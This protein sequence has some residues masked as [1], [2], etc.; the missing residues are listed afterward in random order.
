MLGV[1]H[2]MQALPVRWFEDHQNDSDIF[3]WDRRGEVVKWP[4]HDKPYAPRKLNA[5]RYAGGGGYAGRFNFWHPAVRQIYRDMVTEWSQYMAKHHPG[6]MRY[7]AVGQE[8]SALYASGVNRTTVAAFRK[9]LEDKYGNISNLNETWTTQYSGFDQIDPKQADASRPNGLMY[10]L[11]LFRQDSYFDWMRLVRDCAKSQVPDMAFLND[12]HFFAGDYGHERALDLPRMF[13]TYDVVGFH[14]YNADWVWPM[15]RMLD[16]MRKAYGDKPLGNFEWAAGLLCR[17]IFDERRYKACGLRD[18]FEMMGWGRVVVAVWY[19]GSEGFSEGA[20]YWHGG[21]A[22]SV[23]RYSTAYIPVARQRAR[24][25]ERIAMSHRTIDPKLVVME[26]TASQWNGVDARDTMG[27]VA[28]ALEADDWNYGFIHE[29][30]LLEG[31]QSMDKVHTLILP[32]GVALHP[33]TETKLLAWVRQGGHLVAL[34]PPGMFDPYGKPQGKLIEAVAGQVDV[35]YN[36][37]FTH[38]ELKGPSTQARGELNGQIEVLEFAYGRGRLILF[39]QC[40]P[41]PDVELIRLLNTTTPRDYTF[42]H[43][44]LKAIVRSAETQLYVFLINPSDSQTQEDVFIIPGRF[45]EVVDLGCDGA[46]PVKGVCVDGETHV[47]MRLAP[48]EGTVV[49]LTRSSE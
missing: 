41:L 45:C 20:S 9:R 32:R 43:R 5:G 28:L 12:F 3:L 6:R 17:D 7:F 37:T 14:S 38:V 13:E 49:R 33:E 39:T 27:K 35:E 24:R 15:Y 25:F 16:S 22:K 29:Q 31:K 21:T 10:E 2:L 8:Q 42:Q 23:L 1:V 30:P 26:P 48:G 11:Q 46:F 47:P 19:G 36:D 44:R 4:G 40:D 34:L 18:L